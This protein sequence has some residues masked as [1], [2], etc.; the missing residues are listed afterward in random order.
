MAPPPPPPPP[1]VSVT[2]KTALSGIAR[3]PASGVYSALIRDAAGG[4]QITVMSVGDVF[5]DG[6]RIRQI[7]ADAITLAKADETRVVR[8][9]G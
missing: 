3:D 5:G 6:W 8:L 9:Y 4:P 1:D 7:T 2:F